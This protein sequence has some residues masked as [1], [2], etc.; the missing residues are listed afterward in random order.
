[1]LVVSSFNGF[2]VLLGLH[3]LLFREGKDVGDFSFVI[4]QCA[5]Q[6][7]AGILVLELV[8]VSEDLYVDDG[9]D[10]DFL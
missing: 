4:V 3:F 6:L 2:K 5:I 9:A 10:V 1:M 7:S 8:C